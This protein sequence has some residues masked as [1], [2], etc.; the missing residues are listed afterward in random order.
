MKMRVS[1]VVLV[2]RCRLRMIL[3]KNFIRGIYTAQLEKKNDQK[4]TVRRGTVKF[5]SGVFNFTVKEKDW[6]GCSPHQS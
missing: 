2:T 6:D 3:Q 4:E 1:N 5:H